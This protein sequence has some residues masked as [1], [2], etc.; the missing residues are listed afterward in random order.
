M[1]SS[2]VSSINYRIPS[3]NPAIVEDCDQY[4]YVTCVYIG[5]IRSLNDLLRT[6]FLSNLN[7]KCEN[8]QM[9]FLRPLL[10]LTMLDKQRNTSMCTR[11]RPI[12]T[13]MEETFGKD[14]QRSAF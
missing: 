2:S 3:R 7:G 11:H 14:G 6:L 4:V 10:D 5:N 8:Q 13:E 1:H 9:R 12:L